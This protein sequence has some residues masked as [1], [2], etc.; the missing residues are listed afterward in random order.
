MRTSFARVG[1]QL[2]LGREFLV[3]GGA[4][5]P[6]MTTSVDRPVVVDLLWTVAPST[7]SNFTVPCVFGDDRW[8]CGVATSCA[9][10]FRYLAVVDQQ[11]AEGSLCRSRSR[12]TSSTSA[13]AGDLASNAHWPQ[14]YRS[15]KGLGTGGLRFPEFLTSCCS[16]A[17]TG[18]PRHRYGRSAWSAGAGLTDRLRS[19]QPPTAHRCSP[20]CHGQIPT[21]VARA[22]RPWTGLAGQRASGSRPSTRRS[23][24][25]TASLV[26]QRPAFIAVSWAGFTTSSTQTRPRIRSRRLDDLAALDEG[27]R[28]EAVAGAAVVHG[29]HQILGHV[30]QTTGQITELAVF[31]AVSA[32]PL[33]AP[34]VE[35]KY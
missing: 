32:R 24:N 29:D 16:A 14:G 6:S 12:P 30:H 4:L 23:I 31:S 2:D 3:A 10:P 25:S 21:V 13:G 11:H 5:L 27:L 34:W 20:R 26:Q 33:R 19:D 1:E 7:F 22:H 8:V 15:R 35:M 18:T 17:G 9:G 28:V